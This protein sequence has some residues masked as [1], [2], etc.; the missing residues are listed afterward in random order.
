MTSGR[1]TPGCTL[2]EA[3]RVARLGLRVV[4]RCAV[5][6]SLTI[7]SMGLGFAVASVLKL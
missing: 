6:L 5:F 7:G 4:A 3:R 1:P 2:A